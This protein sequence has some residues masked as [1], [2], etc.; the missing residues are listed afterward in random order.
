MHDGKIFG[1]FN[2]SIAIW[3]IET[4]T[5]EAQFKAHDAPITHLLVRHGF[6]LTA[7]CDRKI[8]LWDANTTEQL[9]EW[10]TIDQTQ[11]IMFDSNAVVCGRTLID[12]R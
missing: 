4:G 6:I 3:S 9:A 10:Q 12:A 2:E 8:R 11:S 1:G 5:S 7:A